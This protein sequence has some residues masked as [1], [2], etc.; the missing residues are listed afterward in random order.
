MKSEVYNEDCMEGMKRYPD[1]Y[2]NLSIVDP[3]YGIG[4]TTT[5]D[6]NKKRATLHKRFKWNNGIPP[7]EYFTEIYLISK[8]QIIWGCNYFYPFIKVPGR[9]VH[10]KKPFQNLDEGKIKFCPC[11]LASQSF[12]NR[13]EF[14]EY[15]WYGN[16][17]GGIPNFNNDG[18]DARIHPTQ[19]PISLYKFLLKKYAKPGDKILDTHLGSGSSRIA[20]Y[21]GG[22]DFVGFEIDKEY[23]DASVK[24]FENHIK[25]LTLNFN[26]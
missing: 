1:K 18:P 2:F 11:D 4:N 10:Y 3:P 5:S 14:F 20:C 6:G 21:D 16:T 17:Q 22:F 25:Q 13:I 9:V 19:K 23:F 26:P 8:N 24:R 12:N 7:K 15:N